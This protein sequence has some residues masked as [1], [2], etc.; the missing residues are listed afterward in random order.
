MEL[1]EQSREPRWLDLHDGA[2]V[3]ALPVTS[4]IVYVAR[5]R[6]DALMTSL[7]ESGEAVTR[8]GAI[9]QGLP[10]LDDAAAEQ[11]LW[12]LL[13]VGSVAEIAVS[14]WQGVTEHGNPLAFKPDRLW[15]LIADAQ[16][17]DLLSAKLLARHR[18]IGQEGNA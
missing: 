18:A 3:L 9:V 15:R 6:A 14:D 4:A 10:D 2:R 5:A 11:G 12:D 1:T 16:T 17:A 7:R 8:V 13:F